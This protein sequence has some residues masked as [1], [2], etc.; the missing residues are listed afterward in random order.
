M[1]LIA[2]LG[3][4][5]TFWSDSFVGSLVTRGFRVV[6]IDNRDVGQSTFVAA[7]PPGLWRQIAARP[8]GD[9]YALA[10]MA[11]DGIGV[12]DHLG[13][14]RAHLVG[15]SMGGMIA[16][17]IAAAAPERVMSLTSLYSTTGAKKVGRPALSTIRL[18]AAP[19]AR[20]RTAAVRAHLRL[21][22]HVAGT[23]HPIDDAAE[24]AIA[25][26]G[27]DRS[28]GE[29]AAGTARQIQAIQRSGD[30]TADL[31]RI[32]APTLVINGDRDP[33]VDPSGGAA[34][35][36]A[37]RSAQH[38]VIP[39]MGHHI[40]EALVDPITTYVS[41]HANRVGEGGSHVRIS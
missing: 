25:A 1:L 15:R 16:Q 32:T 5:L 9:A 12:L 23:D 41:Q 30:R 8:R 24:A 2:G 38:V 7:P 21:T 10:D 40:P 34:T 31:S 22:R 4:D 26:R 17:T 6:A 13:I 33:L 18:L 3:E 37:I 11:E 39:G 14:S 35:V 29:P 36:R 19:P 28:A 27:W 20:N